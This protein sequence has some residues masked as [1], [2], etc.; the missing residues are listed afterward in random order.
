MV[1]HTFVY[2]GAVRKIR[3]LDRRGRA[4]PRPLLR[5]GAHQ[6][7]PV[8]A[9]LQRDLGSRA[10]RSHD[11]GLRA[12]ADARRRRRAGSRRSACR[13]TEAGEPRVRHGRLR[14]R[15]ARARP[16]Q[17][18][19]AGEDAAHDHRR[20]QEDDRV[21]R[22]VAGRA[23]EGLR[24]LGRRAAHRQGVGVRAQR[25]VSL[26]RRARRRSSTVARRSRRWRR[27]SRRRASTARRRRRMPRPAC[28]SCACSRPRS[29]SLE[30][31]GA[32]ET[33]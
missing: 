16:R 4:R 24:E 9:R 27:R 7:R 8:P 29:S 30:H 6:P 14:R 19:R 11:H 22:H 21:G 15:P 13:T 1:D 28:G 12:V 25:A 10:A 17:L 31:Q 5:L 20:R 23:G 32:R 26:G 33:L 3:E 2:T 18:G